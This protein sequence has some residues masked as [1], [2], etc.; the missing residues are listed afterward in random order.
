LQLP[1]E[2]VGY[3][4]PKMG[5]GVRDN[6]IGAGNGYWDDICVEWHP[7]EACRHIYAFKIAIAATMRV[8]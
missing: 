3:G 2:I 4:Y 5:S 6:F 8:S 1:V 7:L